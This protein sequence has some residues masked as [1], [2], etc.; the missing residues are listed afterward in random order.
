M[1]NKQRKAAAALLPPR[2]PIEERFVRVADEDDDRG[3][4][5]Q[6]A[7]PVYARLE[8]AGRQGHGWNP[9]ISFDPIAGREVWQWDPA[10]PGY[11]RTYGVF[12]AV[13]YPPR[14]E[15]GQWRISCIGGDDY[16][17]AKLFPNEKKAREMWDRIRDHV[18]IRTLKRLGFAPD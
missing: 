8:A 9:A 5:Q 12:H 15:G 4:R 10:F 2:P 6:S 13:L 17:T 1:S 7:N 11:D 3:D 18:T 16:N 14:S